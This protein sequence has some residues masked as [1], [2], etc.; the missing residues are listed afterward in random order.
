MRDERGAWFAA[1]QAVAGAVVASGRQDEQRPL[2]MSVAEASS[3]RAW[4]RTADGAGD[5]GP[6]R[7]A[8]GEPTPGEPTSERRVRATEASGPY[9]T[10]LAMPVAGLARE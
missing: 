3:S 9:L 4:Y 7:R 6:A 2:L 5:D 1:E 10:T 8:P